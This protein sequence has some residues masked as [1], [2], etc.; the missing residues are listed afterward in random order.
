MRSLAA[1][2]VSLRLILGSVV[3]WAVVPGFVAAAA[4]APTHALGAG[5]IDGAR[6]AIARPGAWNG[7]LLLHA[8]GYRME[9]APLSATLNA[10][11][12]AYGPWLEDGWIIA[13]TSYRR[14]GLIIRDA[15]A[16]LEALHD[17]IARTDGT[18]EL[19]LLLGESMGGLIVTLLAEQPAGRYHGAVA[20]GA[21]LDLREPE[22]P[23]VP[24]GTPT[25]PLLFL[26]N[27]SELAGPAAYVEAARA[28]PKPPALW[29][30]ARDGH[31]NVNAAERT[32]AIQG[33]LEWITTGTIDRARNATIDV[34]VTAD[35]GVEIINGTAH[36]RVGSVTDGHGNL[37]TT[38]TLADFAQLGINR[39]D[40]FVFE[41]G[42]RT[43]SV[44]YGSDY[45]DVPVGEWVAFPR[46]EGVI[47]IAI[48][49]GNAAATAAVRVGDPLLI[50]HVPRIPPR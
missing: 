33:V 39:G 40:A 14:N 45:R 12:P 27:Q 42:G 47:L 1:S 24:S 44:T 50:R 10:A 8:H 7:R 34:A 28:T 16:D 9:T 38:F 11:D 41:A 37:F 32:A 3:L 19:V 4:I 49:R 30:I 22:Q 18:P 26:T 15:I 43:W 13:T 20:V 46:A 21:A 29:I 5:E 31:V 17:H 36:G 2:K 35:H 25:I 6:Y 23:L 48:N